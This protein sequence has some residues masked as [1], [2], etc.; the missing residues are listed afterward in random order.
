MHETIVVMFD[1]SSNR[2]ALNSRDVFADSNFK[3]KAKARDFCP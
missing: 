3:V 2:V 1:S